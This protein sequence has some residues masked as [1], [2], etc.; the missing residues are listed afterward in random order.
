M[1]NFDDAEA[2]YRD[3]RERIKHGELPSLAEFEEQVGELA[4]QDAKGI[5]WE[6]HPYNARWM[7]Y[8]GAQWVEGIPP[9]Q[10]QCVVMAPLTQVSQR[11]NANST[12]NAPVSSIQRR[13]SIRQPL[14][15]DRVSSRWERLGRRVPFD[16][17]HLWIPFAAGAVVLLLCGCIVFLGGNLLLSETTPTPLPTQT[18]IVRRITST[19]QPTSTL[20][21][22]PPLPTA[23]PILVR[24][25]VLEARVNVRAAPSL[26]GKIVG[27]VV[28]DQEFT[29][30]GRSADSA[31]Y[32]VELAD[33]AQPS[34]VSAQTVQ[35]IS[36]QITSLPITQ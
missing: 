21:P 7:Y 10:K 22:T 24:A 15:Q 36:G 26:D 14:H 25:K 3:M 34:W 23:T 9:G 8:N 17:S 12:P 18:A 35:V 29:I 16:S 5:W 11:F 31:W 1:T 30:I 28:R 4:T 19:V 2:K 20:Q 32:Q 13:A 6:I 33:I 27:R